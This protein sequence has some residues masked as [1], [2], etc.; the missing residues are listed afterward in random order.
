M[1]KVNKG[2]RQG[3]ILSLFLLHLYGEEIMRTAGLECTGIGVKYSGRVINN[4]R[5]ADDTTIITED[6]NDLE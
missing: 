5:Y 1:V 6:P 4:L 3:C 2:V